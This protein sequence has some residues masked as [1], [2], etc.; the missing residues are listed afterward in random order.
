MVAYYNDYIRCYE[1]GRIERLDKRYKNPQ[2][3]EVQQNSCNEHGYLQIEIDGQIRKWHRIIY[4]AFNGEIPEGLQVN[5]IDEN[6]TNNAVSNLNLMTP[7]ENCNYGTRNERGTEKKGKKVLCVETGVIYPS[8]MEAERQTG[9]C[10]SH[11]S[12]CCTGKQKTHGGFHWKYIE[13]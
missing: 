7:K 3:K 5:H 6:K 11:I 2:W 4:I 12:E 8:M 1:D 10:N 9:L 13:E